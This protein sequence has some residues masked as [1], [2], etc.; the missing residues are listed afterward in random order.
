MFASVHIPLQNVCFHHLNN[1]DMRCKSGMEHV[2]NMMTMKQQ[3]NRNRKEGRWKL[4]KGRTVAVRRKEK[5]R[6]TDTWVSIISSSSL[7]IRVHA[8]PAGV[9]CRPAGVRSS[10]YTSASDP[11]P[12]TY[13]WQGGGRDGEGCKRGGREKEGQLE[14]RKKKTLRWQGQRKEIE[15]WEGKKGRKRREEHWREGRWGKSGERSIWKDK[16]EGWWEGGEV[17]KQAQRDTGLWEKGETTGLKNRQLT[18]G[19]SPRWRVV[20]KEK[21]DKQ[22]EALA[23]SHV[24]FW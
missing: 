3:N 21:N 19:N 14:R 4:T 18:A 15:G 10:A 11:P 2:R 17:E 13:P 24:H 20:V 9:S 12:Q 7:L 6:I 5:E 16:E 22:R 1:S 23:N 8:W